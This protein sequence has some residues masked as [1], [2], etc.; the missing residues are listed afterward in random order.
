MKGHAAEYGTLLGQGLAQR[1]SWRGLLKEP[2]MP[3]R[4]WGETWTSDSGAT[5][6]EGE[7]LQNVVP[8]T[9]MTGY[10]SPKLS[11]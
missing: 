2:L 6:F 1:T 10:V 4:F 9:A 7:S 3:R 11:A 8:S 5:G